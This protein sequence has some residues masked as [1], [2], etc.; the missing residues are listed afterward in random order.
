[1]KAAA[2]YSH[3][4]VVS[5]KTVEN[6]PLPIPTQGQVLIKVLAAGLNP[7]DVKLMSYKIPEFIIPLPK[8]VGTDI[9]GIV[10]SI[11]KCK[12]PKFK[13]GDR[14][15]ALLDLLHNHDGAVAEY[16]AVKEELLAIAPSNLTANECA[17]IPL[18]SLTVLQ[19]LSPYLKSINYQSANKRILVQAGAG[20][21]GSF[22]VQYCK[23]VLQMHVFATC[24]AVHI[25]M[26]KSLGADI[27]IDYQHQDYTQIAIGC[28]V[29][30]DCVSY[31]YEE[32]T[33][34]SHVLKTNV[35]ASMNIYTLACVMLFSSIILI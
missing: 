5:V 23:H 21:I 14:V 30:L 16:V 17:S 34:R 26:V 8:V 1:M 12:H 11:D 7:R 28:D 25:P 35:S 20:G 6:Y 22:A 2:F 29:V 33:L 9:C 18:V 27:A 3:D 15:Y 19:A 24:S 32:Q 10:V 31:I 13:V 4:G